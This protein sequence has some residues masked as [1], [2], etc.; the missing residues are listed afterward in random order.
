M[1]SFWRR[2]QRLSSFTIIE[3]QTHIS[4]MLLFFPLISFHLS[5]DLVMIII[6]NVSDVSFFFRFCMNVESVGK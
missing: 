4:K 5:I 1:C 2:N 3:L 6:F